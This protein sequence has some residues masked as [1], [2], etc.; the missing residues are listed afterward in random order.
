[1]ALVKLGT[2]KCCLVS[3]QHFCIDSF[4]ILCPKLA[5]LVL[6]FPGFRSILWLLPL[7]SSHPRPHGSP[8]L[9]LPVLSCPN[10]SYIV[11]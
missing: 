10:V 2:P 11:L 1:M 3:S 7:D 6:G 8:E 9:G 5:E 4:G